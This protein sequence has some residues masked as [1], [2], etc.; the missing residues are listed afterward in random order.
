MA[1]TVGFILSALKL[2][3]LPVNAEKKEMDLT[4]EQETQVKALLG[5]KYED[6][7]AAINKELEASFNG[8]L[9]LVAIQH[10]LDAMRKELDMEK[11]DNENPEGNRGD[12][13][14]SA[15]L[16]EIRE[17]QAKIQSDFQK[18]VDEGVGDTGQLIGGKK[19]MKNHSST[20]LFASTEAYNAFDGGRHWNKRA[21]GL[22]AGVSNFN[23]KVDIPILQGDIENFVRKNPTVLES[24]F[25]DFEGLPKDWGK[26]TGIIDRVVSGLIAPSEITQ[27]DNGGWNPKGEVVIEA[28]EG[29]VFDKKI[30]ITLTGEQLK[31][32]EKSW[33]NW[34]NGS[35]GSHPWKDTFVGFLLG[36]YI[37]Q[38]ALDSRIA[39][40]NGI[41]VK[42]PK[43]ITGANVNS[44]NGIRWMWWYY[45]DVLKKY[46]PA[47]IGEP[48]EENIVDYV[49]AIIN[50]I[51]EKNRNDQGF[52]IQLSNY[53]LKKY[54]ER[55]GELY[56]LNFNTDSGKFDY[57]E[58]YP[59]DRPNFKFQPLIDMNNTSFI[60]ITKSKNVELLSYLEKENNSFTLTRDKRDTHMFAD[61][62]E[63]I[64]FIQVGRKRQSSEKKEFEF[65]M[66]YSNNVAVFGSDVRVPLFD[67]NSTVVEL[68]Y[69]QYYPHMEIVQND[70]STNIEKIEGVIPGMIVSIKGNANLSANRLVKNNSNLSIGSDFQLNSGGTL[71][72]IVMPDLT[73]KQLKRTTTPESTAPVA[74]T[75]NTAVVD[76][77]EGNEFKF[78][79]TVT[80]AITSIINGVENKVVKLYGTDAA[81]VDVT[82]STTGNISV[83][84]AATLG[85]SSK[86]I[87]LVYVAGTWYEVSRSV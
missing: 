71:T 85:D 6:V 30:D 56:H 72:M 37:K 25:D 22:E 51:P 50:T 31:K 55:A 83:A 59:V 62:K 20:H 13:S 1:K 18:M 40:V 57:K 38:A 27:G 11:K 15:Q 81:G 67:R 7:R 3:T 48:T 9:D 46:T 49:E 17:K 80:T 87:E 5:E 21:A 28:E 79:G 8:N 63:G 78:N 36:E 43:T 60:G 75:F 10:E 69:P 64:R 14:I 2:E 12:N 16:K 34:L 41:F 74:K 52:E 66:L 33:I 26:Q 82:L 77:K 39:Q 23:D 4:A 68:K 35:D 73:L 42:S 24:V 47:D 61:F 58:S 86:Y 32:I 76:V 70:Y 29:R 65:Q 19:S 53:W 54:R 44:Q 45:R 84:S